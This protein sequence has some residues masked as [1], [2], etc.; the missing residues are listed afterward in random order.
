MICCNLKCAKKAVKSP[1]SKFR[2]SVKSPST[3]KFLFCPD[4][5][6]PKLFEEIQKA[7]NEQESLII[8]NHL[9]LDSAA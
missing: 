3:D 2:L 7:V 9:I 1:I 4:P 8:D 6:C 5:N